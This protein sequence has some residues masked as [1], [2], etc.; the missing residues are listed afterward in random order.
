MRGGDAIERWSARRSE[1]ERLGGCA[2]GAL[3][4]V[5]WVPVAHQV[6]FELVLIED[7]DGAVESSN[8]V[9]VGVDRHDAVMPDH[10]WGGHVHVEL[11]SRVALVPRNRPPVGRYEVERILVPR[12]DGPV[13]TEHAA[14]GP[15]PAPQP[16]LV[17][18]EHADRR[19][20][21]RDTAP[22]LRDKFHFQSVPYAR[23]KILKCHAQ[24]ASGTEI[25]TGPVDVPGQEARWSGDFDVLWPN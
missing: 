3:D 22:L 9:E 5:T 1:G 18:A 8:D 20:V 10:R 25:R 12:K 2:F 6:V 17:V 4:E 23:Q 21:V 16:E 15:A 24:L 14:W 7:L 19:A 13:T 11:G